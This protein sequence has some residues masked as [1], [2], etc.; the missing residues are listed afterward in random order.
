MKPFTV[1][2][3]GATPLP[4]PNVD[5]DVI[6]RVERLS[7]QAGLEDLKKYAFEAL[8][9]FPDGSENPQCVLNQ[10]ARS[11][12][13]ILITGPNF[14]CGSSREPA[15]WAIMA[16]GFRCVIA[17]SFGD[18]FYSNCF[19]N[20]VLP[21][22]LPSDAIASLMDEAADPS[23]VFSVDLPKQEITAPSGRKIAFQV[24]P[25]RRESLIE[26]LDEIGR[27]L[28]MTSVIDHWQAA[29][30][31]KRPWIWIEPSHSLSTES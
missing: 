4:A 7:S 5:T 3:G 19:Q 11:H 27:T 18:I 10:P 8:R 24:D 2:T 30:R 20:G 14:G 29:D 21:I 28:K 9:Y 23:G 22:V 13:S 26:G 12:S 25:Q 15:V 6:I 17:E 31:V 1:V 16:L